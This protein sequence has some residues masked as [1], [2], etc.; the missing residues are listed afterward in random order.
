MKKVHIAQDPIEAHLVKGFL[1]TEGIEVMI[2]GEH[3]FAIRGW[4]PMTPD[5]LPSVWVLQDAQFDRAE[6]LVA[7]FCMVEAEGCV[8]CCSSAPSPS[9]S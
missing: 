7:E 4:V 1:E 8:G 5:T 9:T 2:Q 3:L 6:E